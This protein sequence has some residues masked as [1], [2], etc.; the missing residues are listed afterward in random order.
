MAI[1][2]VFVGRIIVLQMNVNPQAE[3]NAGKN[4]TM[5]LALALKEKNSQ[6]H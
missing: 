6:H 2:S 4:L 5:P 1:Y 3:G